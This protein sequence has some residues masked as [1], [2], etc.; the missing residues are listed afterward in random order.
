MTLNRRGFIAATASLSALPCL[1]AFA[2]AWPERSVRL[3][4][5][6]GA[7]GSNDIL[8][9]QLGDYLSGKLGQ[10]IVIENK[11]GAGTRIAN[12]YVARAAPD[13]YTPAARGCTDRDRRSALQGSAL[14]RAQELRVHREHGHRAA[15]PDRECRSA[16][17]DGRRI[18]RA[19]KEDGEGPDLRLARR[20]VCAP[21]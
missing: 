18:R 9:R 4:S 7:G 10:G 2:Q 16:L 13:G 21:T 8:S 17:Q 12:E 20:R 6:Y 14:R 15:F 3:V 11:S 1:S 5:P 19:W